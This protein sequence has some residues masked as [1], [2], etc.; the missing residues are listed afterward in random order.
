MFWRM[1][2]TPLATCFSWARRAVLVV[3]LLMAVVTRESRPIKSD[4]SSFGV[5]FGVL[6]RRRKKIRRLTIVFPTASGES[7]PR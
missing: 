5:S 6:K 1:T 7:L 3:M 4:T 2:L